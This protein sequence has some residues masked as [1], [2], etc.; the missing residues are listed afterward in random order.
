MKQKLS[1]I[2]SKKNPISLDDFLK[3]KEKIGLEM[4]F[5]NVY[6]HYYTILSWNWKK[7]LNVALDLKNASRIIDVSITDKP[8]LEWLVIVIKYINKYWL[9]QSTIINE[10]DMKFRDLLTSKTA[11]PNIVDVIAF[12]Q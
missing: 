8:K 5:E 1:Q 11:L 3:D 2:D 10:G 9:H 6:A 12:P 4:V 7:Y